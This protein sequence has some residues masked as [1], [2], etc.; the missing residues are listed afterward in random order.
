MRLVPSPD[1]RS[2]SVRFSEVLAALSFALDTF[3]D[4]NSFSRLQ[5]N[6]MS[7]DF[8]WDAQA[9]LYGELY[10]RLVSL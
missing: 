4:P 3:A 6:G 7:R 5:R 1:A 10:Q 2:E 9:R 8:S